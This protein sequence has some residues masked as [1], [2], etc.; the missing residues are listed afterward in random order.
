[1]EKILTNLS[2]HL[3][4][5]KFRKNVKNRDQILEKIFSARKDFA[6]LSHCI[7]WIW[8]HV[9][10]EHSGKNGKNRPKHGLKGG[11]YGN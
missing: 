3:D 7:F 9:L 2:E 4:F 8:V 11:Q 1:M 5:E 6:R 10:T